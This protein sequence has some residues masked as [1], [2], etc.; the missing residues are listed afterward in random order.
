MDRGRRLPPACLC[1]GQQA[2]GGSVSRIFIEGNSW[3]GRSWVRFGEKRD[4]AMRQGGFGCL[5]TRF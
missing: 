4:V 3:S 5:D 1:Y 2:A